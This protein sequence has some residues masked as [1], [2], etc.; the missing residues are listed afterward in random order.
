MG[1]AP[2]KE[3]VSDIDMVNEAVMEPTMRN[4]SCAIREVYNY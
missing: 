1:D 3:E 4:V 2:N